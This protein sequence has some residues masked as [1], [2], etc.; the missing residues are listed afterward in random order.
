MALFYAPQEVRR[1]L[2]HYTGVGREWERQRRD[3]DSIFDVAL[4]IDAGARLSELEAEQDFARLAQRV[5]PDPAVT[6][7]I[8]Q[9]S[10]PTEGAPSPSSRSRS[11]EMPTTI[12]ETN[13]D[14]CVSGGGFFEN[15]K[16]PPPQASTWNPITSGE[17]YF[18]ILD[19]MR[20]HAAAQAAARAEEERTRPARLAAQAA[21]RQIDEAL[22]AARGGV[23][24]M[25]CT[26]GNLLAPLPAGSREAVMLR[27]II[28]CIEAFTEAP[29]P[30]AEAA[31]VS[32][33]EPS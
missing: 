5:Q 11:T 4:A 28:G 17:Q 6:G 27:A 12:I 1:R 8:A 15:P 10:N 18:E 7:L 16:A 13:V 2:A 19:S 21:Q 20:A 31:Q 22:E 9:L 14:C 26:L 3:N 33:K 25:R 32:A 23:R 29:A 30:P 24:W